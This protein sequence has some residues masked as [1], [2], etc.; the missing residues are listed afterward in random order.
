MS[1]SVSGL[2]AIYSEKEKKYFSLFFN[3][4]ATEIG[5]TIFEILSNT[6]FTDSQTIEFFKQLSLTTT[7]YKQDFDAVRAIICSHNPAK[8]DEH[9][10]S[11]LKIQWLYTLNFTARTIRVESLDF[12]TQV[13]FENLDLEKLVHIRN[14]QTEKMAKM[15][16]GG[17][18]VNA[19]L[20]PITFHMVMESYR[21]FKASWKTRTNKIEI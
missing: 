7:E 11:F 21:K 19:D 3:E 12:F 9:V 10:S 16:P 17:S 5:N 13:S 14:V 2:V 8:F 20:I 1:V 15:Y 4:A 18:N 6:S